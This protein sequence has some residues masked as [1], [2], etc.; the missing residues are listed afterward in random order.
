MFI[1]CFSSQLD[2]SRHFT[3][4]VG[5]HPFTDTLINWYWY[6]HSLDGAVSCSRTATAVPKD[7]TEFF[8]Y[9]HKISEMIS[10]SIKTIK[11]FIPGLLIGVHI[12]LL[13]DLYSKRICVFSVFVDQ[14]KH[15]DDP[16]RL[17]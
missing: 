1:K 7:S 5:I 9:E 6:I 4:Q 13:S 10:D 12:Q 8:E 14:I 3:L 15:T 11:L 16:L 17:F 2:Q